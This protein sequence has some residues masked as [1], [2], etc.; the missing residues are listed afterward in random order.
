ELRER[1]KSTLLDVDT[2]GQIV[3]ANKSFRNLTGYAKDELIGKKVWELFPV[4]YRNSLKARFNKEYEE[5][6]FHHQKLKG[7]MK[8]KKGIPIQIKGTF[9]VLN[10]KQG[11]ILRME[12]SNISLQKRIME[13]LQRRKEK[14]D[15]IVDKA[16][17]FT[18]RMVMRDG[19]PMID[20]V[21]ESF[22][23]LTGIPTQKILDHQLKKL[24][25][26]E[27]KEKLKDC[28]EF[29]MNGESCTCRYR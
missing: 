26:E 14:Y 20:Y 25:F 13:A 7:I 16:T 12:I 29:A 6:D 24:I 23:E 5:G 22:T 2:D 17:D 28:I 15:K 11:T 4:K 19:K 10:L 8:H 27:D 9:N 18:Y 3:A 21:S 1:S